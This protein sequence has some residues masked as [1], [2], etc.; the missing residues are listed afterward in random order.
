MLSET[1]GG[2][3]IKVEDFGGK[4]RT[5]RVKGTIELSKQTTSKGI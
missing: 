3:G 2:E 4:L 1:L 5:D